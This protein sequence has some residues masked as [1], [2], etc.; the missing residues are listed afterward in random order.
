MVQDREVVTT[1]HNLYNSSNC[2][3]LECPWTWA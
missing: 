1:G 3:D 2:D